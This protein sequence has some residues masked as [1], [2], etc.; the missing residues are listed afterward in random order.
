MVKPDTHQWCLAKQFISFHKISNGH[1]E[2][3]IA[4]A[5]VANLG[6]WEC[7]KNLRNQVLVKRF[8]LLQQ[9]INLSQIIINKCNG[10][11]Q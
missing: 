1:M 9:P 5:P 2:I 7:C 3:R 6:E 8:F 11:T 10:K 4:A